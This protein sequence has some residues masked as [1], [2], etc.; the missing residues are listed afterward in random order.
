MALRV[1]WTLVATAVRGWIDDRAGSMGAALAYYTAFSLAPL[2]II[3]IA[4]AGIVFGHDAA[5]AA[6]VAQFEG[7][8]GEAGAR[9]VSDVLRSNAGFGDGLV[10]LAVGIATLVLGATTAFVELQDDLDR[11]F[12]APARPGGG[13]WNLVRTRLLSFAMVL[14]IGFLLTVSL[15]L[16]AAVSALGGL[17]PAAVEALVQ[18]ATLALSF[19]L[20][21]VLF[22]LIY[23]FLPD[24]PLTWRNVWIGAAV[25]AFLFEIGKFAIGL[26][27]GR[28]AVAASFGAAGPF[29]VLMLWIYYS[30]QIFLFGAELTCAHAGRKP[31][32]ARNLEA[33]A[34]ALE[35]GGFA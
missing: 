33:P 26:Y 34:P 27:I 17:L 16:S 9:A 4:V 10:A 25:T 30:T 12:R 20:F 3:V 5:Q 22:A 35:H 19:A 13:A 21:T 15:I 7:L 29:V 2:L 8:T 32:R 24:A 14:F 23:K 31:A 6:V 11:I 18:V 28:S 1:A